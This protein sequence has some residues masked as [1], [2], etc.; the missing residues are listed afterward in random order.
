MIEVTAK[1]FV[2]TD[3]MQIQRQAKSRDL[4]DKHTK[5]VIDIS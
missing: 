4:T 3:Q 2:S 5:Y 1:V